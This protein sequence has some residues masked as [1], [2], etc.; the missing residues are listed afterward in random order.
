MIAAL[1][2]G[3]RSSLIAALTAGRAAQVNTFTALEEARFS[4]GLFCPKCG[5]VEKII[6]AGR[7]RGGRQRYLCRNCSKIFTSTTDTFMAFSKKGPEVWQ[8]YMRCYGSRLE[9]QASRG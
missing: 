7:G 8:R 1:P 9:H 2:S 5:S 3:E 4:A 6:K